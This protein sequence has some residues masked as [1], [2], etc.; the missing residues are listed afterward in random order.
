MLVR[1]QLPGVA[2]TPLGRIVNAGNVE[3]RGLEVSLTYKKQEGAVKFDFTLNVALLDNKIVSIK[4]GLESLEPLNAPRVRSLPLSNIYKVGSP[5]GAFYGYQTDG[6]FQSNGDAT[7]YVNSKGI[8][9]Q[10]NAK[11]G[12]FKF[13]DVNGDGVINNSDRV[14]LGTPFPKNTF[15]LN[16]NVNYKGFDLNVFL[17]GVS[18]NSV[19]N[20]VKYTGVNASFPGYNLLADSKNAWT[21]EN[22][23]ATIPK[24]SA[25]DLNNNFGRISDFYIE[26]A[27]FVR[28]RN[29]SIGYTLN[30]KWLNY[31][32]TVK[33]YISA[34]NLFTITNYSGMDPEVG[35]SNF[36]IDVGRYPLSRIYMAG[37]NVTF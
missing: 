8:L 5:V 21:P 6:L 31:K 35:L 23:S 34:Q 7:A 18:G 32:A 2:G 14:V 36:G 30:E 27:S 15:S 25:S 24:I 37:V 13:K 9:Y 22:P 12:D 3:N 10:A 11:A 4:E 28:L 19:F 33:F 26:D 16:S 1:D 17:Q 20:A 29:I